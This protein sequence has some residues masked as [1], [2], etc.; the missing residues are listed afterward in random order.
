MRLKSYLNESINDKGILKACF[1][2]GFPG[3]G[4]S[5]VVSRIKSGQIEPR[6]VNIDKIVEFLG[7]LKVSDWPIIQD[8]VRHCTKKQ[9]VSYIN[10][11]LP[12]WVDGTCSKPSSTMRRDGILKSVGYDTAMIWIDTTLE[13]AIERSKRREREVS[14]DVIKKMYE[15]LQGV[16]SYYAKEFRHFV[17]IPNDVDEL[18]DKLILQ[19]YNNMTNYFSSP[20]KNPIG[21]RIIRR[22]I[23]NGWKYL[24]ETDEYNME[25]ISKLVNGWW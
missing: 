24:S 2:S 11:L 21:I 23:E 15:R 5:Y 22:M 6:I 3:S 17:E 8:K 1:M 14:E 7:Y 13:T 9:L 16:K 25:G 18:N 19:A 10:S 20:V 4:K 12:M